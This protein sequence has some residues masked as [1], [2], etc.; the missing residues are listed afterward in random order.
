VSVSQLNQE[1]HDRKAPA[2]D[3]DVSADPLEADDP[4]PD[5]QALE[6]L[7]LELQLDVRGSWTPGV[8]ELRRWARAALGPLGRGREITV[9]IVRR[10]ESRALNARFRGRNMPT[11]VLSFPA[12]ALPGLDA[13]PGAGPVP[14]GDLVICAAV[15]RDEARAQGKTLRAHWAHLV[16]HGALHLVGHDHEQARDAARM[17]SLEVRVLRGLG[18]PDPYGSR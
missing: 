15:V 4:E 17:E 5:G 18:F 6:R 7:Q 9:R 3:V 2:P 12:A 14:L 1:M 11:N 13:G 16:V 10:H 8:G